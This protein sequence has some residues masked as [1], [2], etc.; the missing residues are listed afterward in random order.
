MS[1]TL[2]QL[3]Q[4]AL[5]NRA[6]FSVPSTIISNADPTAIRLNMAADATGRALV[7]LA[8]W[9]GIQSVYTFTTADGTDN[10]ALPSGFKRMVG[11]TQWNRTDYSRMEGPVDA[12]KWQAL[13][14]G[15]ISASEIVQYWRIIAGRMY[16]YP[17][18]SSAD[19]IAFEYSGQNWIIASGGTVP[20]KEYFD[21]DSDTCVFSDDA[22]MLGIK[23]RYQ[24]I[25]MGVEF[26]P[27]KEYTAMLGGDVSSDGGSTIIDYGA[28]IRPSVN[29]P[30]NIAE[31]SWPE[32]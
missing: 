4:R 11:L 5:R 1:L 27:S 26:E 28:R 23:E 6:V 19:T 22:M 14:S 7:T 9:Q 31:G 15:S 30:G 12:A 10:Y 16:I 17:T 29:Y 21:A 18:P 20:T 2:V 24:A 13:V 8:G 32:S 3:C 25:V